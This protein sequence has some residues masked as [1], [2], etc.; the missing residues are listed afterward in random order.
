MKLKDF[1][2]NACVGNK[3]KKIRTKLDMTEEQLAQEVGTSVED[4]SRYES[5]IAPVP[6]N[7]FFLISRVFNVSVIELL[8]DYFS[9]LD[10]EHPLIY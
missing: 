10:H 7:T 3:I 1:K 9:N 6:V 2:L 5:G 8:S 4:I